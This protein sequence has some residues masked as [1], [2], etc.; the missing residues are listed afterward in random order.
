MWRHPRLS[1]PTVQ[2]S[3]AGTVLMPRPIPNAGAAL[4][5]PVGVRYRAA[6]RAETLT[7]NESLR[8]SKRIGC[9]PD[10][11]GRPVTVH[12]C[13]GRQVLD[14]TASFYPVWYAQFVLAAWRG[15][16][17]DAKG[18]RWLRGCR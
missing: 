4:C 17:L 2:A 12:A 18:E 1:W 6:A 14:A 3:A 7:R 5:G 16:V 8:G 9:R 15:E 10:Q 11:G 13:V